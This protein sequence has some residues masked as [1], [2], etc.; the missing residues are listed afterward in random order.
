MKGRIASKGSAAQPGVSSPMGSH[1]AQDHVSGGVRDGDLVRASSD[2][3][4]TDGKD[5][6]A[7]DTGQGGPGRVT[8]AEVGATACECCRGTGV[9]AATPGA[10]PSGLPAKRNRADSFNPGA[11]TQGIGTAGRILHR[12]SAL[13][14]CGGGNSQ[15][16]TTPSVGGWHQV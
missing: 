7:K 8:K 16:R 9:H 5:R 6:A 4:K 2:C 3:H 15:A 10:G 11:Y 14:G 12:S 1:K 13:H